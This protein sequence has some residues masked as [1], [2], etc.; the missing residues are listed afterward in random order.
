MASKLSFFGTPAI[1]AGSVACWRWQLLTSPLMS[2]RYVSSHSCRLVSPL[3]PDRL[4]AKSHPSSLPT[5]SPQT[6]GGG[7]VIP[8][9]GSNLVSHVQSSTRIP[10]LGHA[11]GICHLYIDSKA[12]IDMACS[13]AVDCKVDNPASCNAVEKILVHTDLAKDGRL[14]QLQASACGVHALQQLN[15]VIAL[16]E[17]SGQIPANMSVWCFW[18]RGPSGLGLQVCQACMQ[19]WLGEGCR[20]CAFCRLLSSRGPARLAPALVAS[21]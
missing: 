3:L 17:T 12:N 16:H 1:R 8:R 7:Q 2:C 9:G 11:H 20:P 10:V 4:I 21:S 19:C 6:C 5:S 14:Y 15:G 13:I 18:A